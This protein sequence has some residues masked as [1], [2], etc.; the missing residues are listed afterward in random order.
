MSSENKD[1][2]AEWMRSFP[3]SAG[4]IAERGQTLD[5]GSDLDFAWYSI[6]LEVL[7]G[8]CDVHLLQVSAD[9]CFNVWCASVL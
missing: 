3:D 2:S 6:G 8:G 7:M 5:W 9:L 4:V 1:S